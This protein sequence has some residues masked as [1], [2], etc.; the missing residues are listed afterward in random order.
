MSY[1][2]LTRQIVILLFLSTIAQVL[3]EPQK[4]IA[5]QSSNTSL[6]R[7]RSLNA[8]TSPKPL[9]IINVFDKLEFI[10]KLDNRLVLKVGE[11]RVYLYEGEKAVASYP[12]AVGKKG[13]E[14]PTGEF[15]VI[16]MVRNPS[17]EHPWNGTIFPPGPENP[18]GERWIGFWSDGKN[19]IGFHGTPSEHTIG[20][21]ASHGCVRMKNQDVKALFDRVQMG[22][23]VI[24]QP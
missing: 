3:H 14:T 20:R 12:V 22:T 24:V 23:P 5:S 19:T 6:I 9:D 16:K 17:W 4:A 2:K 13:W 18:L 8:L 21:A 1:K 10:N 11:R 7:N 15:Q